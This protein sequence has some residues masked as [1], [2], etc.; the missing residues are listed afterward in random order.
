M[1]I[2]QYFGETGMSK[3][4]KPIKSAWKGVCIY[5][6][7]V[8]KQASGIVLIEMIIV[9]AIGLLL[10][11]VLTEMYLVNQKSLRLQT[12]LY[13]SQDNAKTAISILSAEI[14]QAGRIGC[15]RLT[16]EFPMTSIHEY[17]LTPENKMTG[18]SFNEITVRYAAYPNAFLKLSMQDEKTIHASSDIHFA[19]GDILLISNCKRAEIFAVE[20]VKIKNGVQKIIPA[21]S[22]HNLYEKNSEVSRLIINKYYIAKTN[23]THQDGTPVYSLFLQDIRHHK[24]ELVAGVDSMRVAYSVN[25]AGNWS[26]V[27]ANQV[28]DWKSVAGVAIDFD[29]NTPPI[30]KSWHMYAVLN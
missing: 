16:S 2:F 23:R 26:E 3:I 17:R 8:F 1:R 21:F 22:L 6:S 20:E 7:D 15:A 13:D 25:Y 28:T 11:S 29:L 9:V 27:E 4:A 19:S 12:A 30:K 5:E 24:T 14:H 10:V 18:N